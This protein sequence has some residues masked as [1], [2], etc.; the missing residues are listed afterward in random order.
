MKKRLG[1]K[2]ENVAKTRL[3]EKNE[4]VPKSKAFASLHGPDGMGTSTR[5]VHGL[6]RDC[7]RHI[8]CDRLH[9][10]ASSA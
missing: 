9:V 8:A 5:K 1:E 2:K 6:T 10:C 4:N 7:M 3:H